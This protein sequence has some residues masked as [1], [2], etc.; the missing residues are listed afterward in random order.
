[1]IAQCERVRYETEDF[2]RFFLFE[3]LEAGRWPIGM[4]TAVQNEIRV[5]W[6]LEIRRQFIFEQ[7]TIARRLRSASTSNLIC[8]QTLSRSRPVVGFQARPS[9]TV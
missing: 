1:M 5:K 3:M 7:K 9:D 8:L 4:L 6:R 2:H